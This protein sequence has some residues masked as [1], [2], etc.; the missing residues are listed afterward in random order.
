MKKMNDKFL[1]SNVKLMPNIQLPNWK[2]VIGI[3]FVICN[4]IL[5]IVPQGA[6]ASTSA[7]YA[8]S[9]EVIDLGGTRETSSTYLMLSKLRFY[10]P[11]ATTSGSYTLEGRFTGYVLASVNTFEPIVTSVSPASA[12]GNAGYRLTIFGSNISADATV[13]LARGSN[14]ITGTGI[15]IDASGTSMEADFDLTGQTQGVYNV[16]VTNVG[17]SATGTGYNLFTILGGGTLRIIGRP[18]ND[19]NPFNPSNG[20]THFKFKLNRPATV[21]LYMFNQLGQMVW[22]KEFAASTDNDILWNG[23]SQFKE[24]LPTGVYILSIVA[25]SGSAGEL[26]R[27]RVGILRQ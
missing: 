13:R 3:L 25:K 6:Y 9:A 8:I 16:E 14:I 23:V 10:E 17:Y 19:P 2:L 4:L 22:Q 21:M 27:I 5:V 20:G 15:S 18:N 7:T 12:L 11:Q 26:G 24:D 1:I